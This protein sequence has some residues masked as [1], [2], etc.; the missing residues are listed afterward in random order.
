[1]NSGQQLTGTSV[2]PN[3]G[4]LTAFKNGLRRCFFVQ[5]QSRLALMRVRAVTLKTFVGQ[6]AAYLQ[7]ERHLFFGNG[8]GT[9]NGRNGN[10]GRNESGELHADIFPIGGTELRQDRLGQGH[11]TNR[12]SVALHDIS[13]GDFRDADS[14][15]IVRHSC[16]NFSGRL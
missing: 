14:A 10:Q 7:C 16:G 15:G 11:Q 2:S 9:Q 5:P 1:M 3:D 13:I 4:S 6:N 12:M 8:H